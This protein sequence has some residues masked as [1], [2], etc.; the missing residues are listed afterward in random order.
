MYLPANY[1]ISPKRESFVF[2][3]MPRTLIYSI[4]SMLLPSM[5][6]EHSNIQGVA[7]KEGHFLFDTSTNTVESL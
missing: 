4:Y 1:F 6:F 5:V 3:T 7:L 2:L